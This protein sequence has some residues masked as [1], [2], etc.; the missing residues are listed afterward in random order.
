MRHALRHYHIRYRTLTDRN[1]KRQASFSFGQFLLTK[2]WGVPLKA[3]ACS[4]TPFRSIQ[5]GSDLPGRSQRALKSRAL[6]VPPPD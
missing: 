5:G 2:L 1:I 6:P 4:Q 3:G